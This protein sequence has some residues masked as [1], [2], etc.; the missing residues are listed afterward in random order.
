MYCMQVFKLFT[1]FARWILNFRNLF[2][3]QGFVLLSPPFVKKQFVLSNLRRTILVFHIGSYYDWAT[4]MEVFSRQEYSTARFN[5]HE[6]IEDYLV[7]EDQ[8][9]LL[10]VDLGANI[11]VASRY[12]A[13][14]YP[15][16]RIV[17]VEP[18]SANLPRLAKNLGPIGSMEIVHAACGPEDGTVPVWDSHLGNN[19]FRTY[20]GSGE[21]MGE[22]P[23]VSIGTIINKNQGFSPFLIKIDIEGFEKQLFSKNLDWIDSFK[24]IAIETHD[25]ML[26]GQAISSNFITALANKNRDLVFHGENLFSIRVD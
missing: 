19:A 10:I 12:F 9:K 26:P 16:A 21:V 23:M 22:V 5:N 2:V 14:L 7:R 20:P 3:R 1:S 4:L 25:W 6:L 18:A 15:K 13:E 11:G 24:L 17:A 8:S